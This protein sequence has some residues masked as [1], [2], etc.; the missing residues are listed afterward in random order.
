VFVKNNFCKLYFRH[1]LPIFYLGSVSG[2]SRTAVKF[3]SVFRKEFEINLCGYLRWLFVPWRLLTLPGK[4]QDKIA[5]LD[6]FRD[7]SEQPTSFFLD[8]S[9]K[10]RTYNNSGSRV[11]GRVTSGQQVLSNPLG[12]R[13]TGATEFRTMAYGG[14]VG[15]VYFLCLFY[16]FRFGIWSVNNNSPGH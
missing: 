6:N 14:V 12:G 10:D 4:F 11:S 5:R 1:C 13:I 3:C 16:F 7:K 9:P 8:D 15:I 2:F